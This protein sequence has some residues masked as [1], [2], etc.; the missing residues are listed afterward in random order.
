MS[1]DTFATP[2][3]PLVTCSD[4]GGKLLFELPRME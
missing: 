4:T 1:R 3:L 2:F